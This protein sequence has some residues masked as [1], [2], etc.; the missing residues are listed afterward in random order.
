M[1]EETKQELVSRIV[2]WAKQ[3]GKIRRILALIAVFVLLAYYHSIG[4][5]ICAEWKE[6]YEG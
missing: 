3:G 6:I 1:T 2:M 5:K 4:K